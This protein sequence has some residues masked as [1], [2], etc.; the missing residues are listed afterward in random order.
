MA[1]NFIIVEDK[2]NK[3]VSTGLTFNRYEN[4][5]KILQSLKDRHPEKEFILYDR[6]NCVQYRLNE[7][8]GAK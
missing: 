1:N 6:A 2:G 5:L 7:K 8:E 4:G 3:F